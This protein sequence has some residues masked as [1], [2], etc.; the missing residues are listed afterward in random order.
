MSRE[1]RDSINSKLSKSEVMEFNR[2]IVRK[3]NAN[4]S[5][6]IFYQD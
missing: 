5:Y 6:F 1:Q 2:L 3:P 4:L